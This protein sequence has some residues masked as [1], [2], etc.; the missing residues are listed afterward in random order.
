LGRGVTNREEPPL[1]DCFQNL[2]GTLEMHA[3]ILIAEDEAALRE[4]LGLG[5]RSHGFDTLPASNIKEALRCLQSHRVD[6]VLLDLGL[7][8]ENGIDLLRLIRRLPGGE[9]IPVVLLTGCKDRATVL[10]AAHFGAH[11][12]VLKSQFSLDGLIA[13]IRQQ[14]IPQSMPQ[15][16]KSTLD[17][18]HASEPATPTDGATIL[19]EAVL[20]GT[21]IPAASQTDPIPYHS[22]EPSPGEL[23]RMLR[24]V[25]TREQILEQVD[26]CQDLQAF[27][28]TVAQV[29]KMTAHPNCSLNEIA[30]VI[31]QDQAVSLKVLKLANSVVY[32]RG[33]P[34]DTVQK[35]LARI[36][37]SQIRQLVLNVAVID[38][39]QPSCS[40]DHFQVEWFWEHSIATGLIAAAITRA[41]D[42]DERAIDNAFTSGLLHDV[43]RMVFAQYLQEPYQRVLKASLH[44]QLPLE[45]IESRMLVINHANLIERV[46]RAWKFPESLID[47]IAAHH[48]SVG[49]IRK[50][51]PRR[52]FEVCTLA[53]ADRLAHAL[54]LGSSA[55]D[56]QYPTEEIMEAL[57]L[58]PDTIQLIEDQIVEQA[59]DMKYAMLQSGSMP[60]P[61]DYRQSVLKRLNKAFQPLYL[62]ASA[63]IDGYRILFTR[64][65]GSDVGHTPNVAVIYLAT[66]RSREATLK[67]LRETE[68]QVGVAPLPVIII[69]P[70]TNL[71]FSPQQLGARQWRIIPSPFALSRFIDTANELIAS[72]S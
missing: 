5:L 35:A 23:L 54:L 63:A 29:M 7:G 34:V 2:I 31:K 17:C 24:P 49:A 62:S 33:E 6:L 19:A 14:L 36:G 3:T 57:N 72:R 44:L 4:L 46:L 27:S 22:I 65:K 25:I 12:Y 61:L 9:K 52:V 56:Y 42:G 64:M 55:N 28:P 20:T 60:Q 59:V 66:A 30:R 69:S 37:L 1:Q 13:R 53:L 18:E 47:P 48:H 38:S 40:G 45:Q 10:L 8:R 68:E 15:H 58:A 11:G 32:S 67:E 51:L 50:E 71:K 26:R 21:E 16:Q 39:F 41:R 43:G 70:T